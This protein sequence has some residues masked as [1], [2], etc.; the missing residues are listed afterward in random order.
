MKYS[1]DQVIT[2]IHVVEA[3]SFTQAALRL[4]MSK[5]IVSQRI[6]ALE[7]YLDSQLLIRTTRKLDMTDA[8]R[9]F[10]RGVK[11][12]FSE[13]ETAVQSVRSHQS[14][15]KGKLEVL[16]PAGFNRTLR[17]IAKHD[18]WGK[19]IPDFVAKHP[20]VHLHL[21]TVEDP[22]SC[23]D[24]KFDCLIVPHIKGTPLP[25]YDHVAKK[26]LDS[27]VGIFATPTYFKRYGKPTLPE[28]LES[29]AC[30][31]TLDGP[32]PL[33]QESGGV[34][35]V[36]APGNVSVNDDGILKSLVLNHLA[37]GYVS[38]RLVLDEIEKGVVEEVLPEY[39]QLEAEVYALYPQCYYMP[40][41][42]KV[43]L[44]ALDTIKQYV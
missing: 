34:Y 20:Q 11:N 16:I 13:I 36:N 10:Y 17:E 42:L 32:W 12:I 7:S 38:K 24:Q 44:E 8:G 43:F 26:I 21:R 22:W 30:A 2:F 39:T 9:E 37:L 3:G 18:I 33:K 14:I 25:D 19:V 15:A 1:L 31:S 35:Y 41:K 27:E 29:H 6:T 5:S 23:L 4:N 40:Y 28:D